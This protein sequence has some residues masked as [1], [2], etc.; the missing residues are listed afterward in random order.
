[1]TVYVT[2]E[3]KSENESYAMIKISNM[4]KLPITIKEIEAYSCGDEFNLYLQN[5]IG[6]VIMPNSYFR[7]Y[8]T[9]PDSL[10]PPQ[11]EFKLK[12]TWQEGRASVYTDVYQISFKFR[13]M[14]RNY[15][16]AGKVIL[17]DPNR[18]PEKEKWNYYALRFDL[19][20]YMTETI[21]NLIMVIYNSYMECIRE[22]KEYHPLSDEEVKRIIDDFIYNMKDILKKE[23]KGLEKEFTK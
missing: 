5:L 2:A 16:D 20:R 10:N 11:D 17:S 4:N 23:D 3:T 18:D 8:A 14:F 22:K 1:M 21:H 12:L 6:L 19:D 9:G 13:N 15:K 7:F